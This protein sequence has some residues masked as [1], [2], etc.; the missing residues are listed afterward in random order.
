[1]VH[2]IN[3]IGGNRSGGNPSAASQSR[4]GRIGHDRIDAIRRQRGYDLAAITREDADHQ[5]SLLP[6]NWKAAKAVEA[7]SSA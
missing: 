4:I 5:N 1:M 2:L 7:P 3:N 6:W